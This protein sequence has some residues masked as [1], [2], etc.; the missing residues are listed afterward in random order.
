MCN[1]WY[2]LRVTRRKRR[3][4]SSR[5][6]NTPEKVEGRRRRRWLI[7]PTTNVIGKTVFSLV[8]WQNSLSLSL[9]V[10]GRLLLLFVVVTELDGCRSIQKR[11][12]E[13][14]DDVVDVGENA[15]CRC[16]KGERERE[17][18][19]RKQQKDRLSCWVVV[20]V[21]SRNCV[22]LRSIHTKRYIPKQFSPLFLLLL[23]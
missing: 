22:Y 23:D 9:F 11:E 13:R 8:Y 4:R 7:R 16:R 18:E 19:R 12:R 15:R 2:T 20:V 3:R 6:V 17:S 14:G 5:K 21:V 1:R 10:Q